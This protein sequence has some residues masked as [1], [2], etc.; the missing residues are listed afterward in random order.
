MFKV[1]SLFSGCGGGDLGLKGGFEFLGEHYKKL[2]FKTV[3]ANEI[4]DKI[5]EIFSENFNINPD[6]RD[7]RTVHEDDI[8]EHDILV[9]GFPCVSFSIVAQNPKR[10]GIKN[11]A[12]G[13]LFFEMV[14]VLKKKQPM[15]FIA[16]NVKGLL[17][18]NKG[19]AFPLIVS[20]FENAGYS[21]KYRLLNAAEFG[22]PQNRLRVFI[23]GI[24]NDIDVNFEF[25]E[26]TYF[27]EGT[28]FDKSFI[29][30]KEVIFPESE[31][32]EK[33][34]FSQRAVE[35][36]LKAKK[37]MNKGRAQ[38]IHKPCNTVGAHLAKVSLN[39]TDPVL[40]INDRYRRFTPREVARIQSF[41][42]SYKLV[43][44]EGTQYKALG[45][46]IPPVLMWNVGMKL[47]NALSEFINS[48]KCEK[49]IQLIS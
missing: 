24:R 31:I 10:L 26:P 15:A 23:I 2:P 43:R 44:A 17:S 28:L 36:M 30:L 41:P 20:E 27:Q 7:I 34:Y 33:Y 4:D 14:R 16:E 3:Y 40:K 39:S 47:A 19:E 48:D 12:S 37:D 22:V 25:P 42:D 46:A 9:G 8:P 29:P 11:D 21:V 32:D 35:G 38:D 13:K 45:N 6:V 1:A 18:A 5:A 49:K